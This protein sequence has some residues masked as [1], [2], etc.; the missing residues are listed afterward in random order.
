M[1]LTSFACICA[2]EICM[3][4]VPVP[5]IHSGTHQT[6]IDVRCAIATCI[7]C[8]EKEL[9][10]VFNYSMLAMPADDAGAQLM[11]RPTSYAS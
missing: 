5:V 4:C 6:N 1:G 8:A 3:R 9:V 7:N 11:P 2:H 10:R